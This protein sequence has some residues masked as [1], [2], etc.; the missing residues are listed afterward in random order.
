MPP[1]FLDDEFKK[2]YLPD[3]NHRVGHYVPVDPD[4]PKFPLTWTNPCGIRVVIFDPTKFISVSQD[5]INLAEF[6]EYF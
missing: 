4:L 3:F 2:S 5:F 1:V 6:K